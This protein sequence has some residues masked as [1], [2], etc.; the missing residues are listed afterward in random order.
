MERD[1]EKIW[2]GDDWNV[3]FTEYAMGQPKRRE[4]P[5][6]ERLYERSL[7]PLAL[8]YPPKGPD[9]TQVPDQMV[10]NMR[11]F[12]KFMAASYCTHDQITAWNCPACTSDLMDRTL[13]GD[14][15]GSQGFIAAYLARKTIVVVF[16]GSANLPNWIYNIRFWK[17]DAEFLK[18]ELGAKV[19]SGMLD[20]YKETKDEMVGVLKNMTRKYPGWSVTFA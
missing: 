17:A 15:N 4:E 5:K 18:P 19:H 12:V 11:A 14:Y 13:F 1:R 3:T 9:G 20:V 10:R 6:V 7:A 2:G 8:G 16:R